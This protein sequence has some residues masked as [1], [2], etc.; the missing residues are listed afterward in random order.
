MW[1]RVTG[2]PDPKTQIGLQARVVGDDCRLGSFNAEFFAAFICIDHFL[3]NNVVSHLRHDLVN[4]FVSKFCTNVGNFF[5][6]EQYFG[7]F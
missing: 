3:E 6:C 1:L 7:R 4:F 5:G 2:G